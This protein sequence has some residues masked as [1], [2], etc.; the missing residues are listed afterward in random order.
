MRQQGANRL[1]DPQ[2]SLN[3]CT[4]VMRL[5][6]DDYVRLT[7]DNVERT[8]RVATISGNGQVFLCDHHEA[9]VDK[10]NRD[11]AE[12]FSYISKMAGSFRAARARR[13]TVSPIG[14]LRDGGFLD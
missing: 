4:L 9:N 10:R 11:K 2:R 3:G 6:I 1:R 7:I 12:S 5:M 8:M 14:V 13:V